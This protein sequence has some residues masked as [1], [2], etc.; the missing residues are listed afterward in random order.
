[1]TSGD[2]SSAEAMPAEQARPAWQTALITLA[3]LF[4]LSEALYLVLGA[5]ATICLAEGA[6]CGP[7]AKTISNALFV[8]ATGESGAPVLD[9]VF[10][11]GLPG[12]NNLFYIFLAGIGIDYLA[13]L[14]ATAAASVVIGFV[15]LWGYFAMTAKR[16]IAMKLLLA[17]AFAIGWCVLYNNTEASVYKT[18]FVGLV[19]ARYL[20]IPIGAISI[21]IASFFVQRRSG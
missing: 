4:T 17:I 12:F 6:A 11:V 20:E 5:M 8:N 3:V 21:F 9:S 2:F 15:V 13:P 19:S 1:L 10:S 7:L 16:G 14:L 18:E